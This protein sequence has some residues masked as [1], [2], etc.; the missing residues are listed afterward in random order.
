MRDRLITVDKG[1]FAVDSTHI[2][3]YNIKLI[4][5]CEYAFSSKHV[6]HWHVS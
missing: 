6:L 1:Y 5:Y 3:L 4:A 2:A